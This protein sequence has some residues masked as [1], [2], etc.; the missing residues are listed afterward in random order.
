MRKIF[1]LYLEKCSLLAVTIALNEQGFKTKSYTTPK[2]KTFGGIKFKST[3][4]QLI[5]K[6][7][8]YT[9]KVKYHGQ[10]YQGEQEPII[11]EEI[12]QKAQEI[13]AENRPER[14]I[15]QNAKNIGLLSD[16]LRCKNCNCSMYYAYAM[17]SKYK[18]HY[19]LCMNAQ[20]RGYKSCPT[21]L[22]NAQAIENK[23]IECLKNIIND[24]ENLKKI[25]NFL[26]KDLPREKTITIEKLKD[27]LIITFPLWESFSLQEK[28]RVFKL[29]IKQIDYDAKNE[30]LGVALN[31]NGLK[32][33]CTNID[34]NKKDR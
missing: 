32:F 20:K 9:G 22:V 7:V 5:I 28:R 34:F 31:E 3:G 24:K 33:L 21:R 11:S 2:G 25:L 4:V 23:V 30:V 15:T 29:I 14:K 18:Y 19:Y 16:V 13:L 27:A 1:D 6:N 10:L 26:N 8:Y 12:F 17:K